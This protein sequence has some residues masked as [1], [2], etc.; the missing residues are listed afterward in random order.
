MINKYKEEDIKDIIKLGSLV[1]K[2][3]KNYLI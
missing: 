1:N 3:S 2:N